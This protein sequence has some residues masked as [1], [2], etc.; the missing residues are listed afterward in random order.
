VISS[1]YTINEYIRNVP[2][3]NLNIIQAYLHN[4]HRI[5][6]QYTTIKKSSDTVLNS[7]LTKYSSIV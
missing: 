5:L 1:K 7:R 6:N 4:A 3:Q 2:K